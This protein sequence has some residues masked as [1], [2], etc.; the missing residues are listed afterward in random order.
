MFCHSLHVMFWCCLSSI[1]HYFPAIGIDNFTVINSYDEETQICSVC[2]TRCV[3]VG[4][5]C[6]CVMWVCICCVS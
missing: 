2:H 1:F 4:V 5:L 6:G 3:I